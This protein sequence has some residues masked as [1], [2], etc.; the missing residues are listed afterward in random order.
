MLANVFTAFLGILVF[1]FIFWKRLKEDYIS[2][3]IFKSAFYILIG[4]LV[5]YLLSIKFIPSW[6]IWM[7]FIG[8]LLGLAFGIFTLKIKLYEALEALVISFLPWI[9]LMFLESS[10]VNSSL[11]SFLAFAATLVIVFVS[12]WI[13]DHYKDF[14]WYKSGKIGFAGLATLALIFLTRFIVAIFGIH[15]LSFVNLRYEAILSGVL[16]IAT[17]GLIINLSKNDK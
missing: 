1:L 9:A 11:S 13:G 17:L 6:F 10:V 12:Y 3:I 2:E 4:V 14:T 16:A 15:V 8:S 7:S 5:A